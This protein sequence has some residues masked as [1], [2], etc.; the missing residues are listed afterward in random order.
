MR[1]RLYVRQGQRLHARRIAFFLVGNGDVREAAVLRDNDAYRTPDHRALLASD[2]GHER[3]CRTRHGR[4]PVSSR[5]PAQDRVHPTG[6][7]GK[8]LHQVDVYREWIAET[9]SSRRPR[10]Y[11]MGIPPPRDHTSKTSAPL[12]SANT[13]VLTSKMLRSPWGPAGDAASRA[14]LQSP[15]PW[16]RCRRSG[17]PVRPPASTAHSRRPSR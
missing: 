8:T 9:L 4:P 14:Q 16:R 7:V 15:P 5:D 12:V 11:A 10:C 2:F 17:P 6:E 13:G 1:P 3:E